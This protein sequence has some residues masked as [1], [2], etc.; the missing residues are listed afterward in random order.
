MFRV[1]RLPLTNPDDPQEPAKLSAMYLEACEGYT[2]GAIVDTCEDFTFGR[3]D[4][5]N[6]AWAPN[7]PLFASHLSSVQSHL[8]GPKSL[9]NAAVKQIALRDKD[10]EVEQSRT[11]EA[12][13]RVRSMM[14]GFVESVDPK[15]KTPEEIARAKEDAKR[16][17]AF[18][19]NEFEERIPGVRV[20]SYLINKL[21]QVN[22]EG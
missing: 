22:G 15:Q 10:A 3:V 4:G 11:P 12:M 18:Y 20:S 6:R 1:C 16:H 13:A 21:E 7:V 2:T 14:E 17:D 19:A 9:H 8:N 5:I